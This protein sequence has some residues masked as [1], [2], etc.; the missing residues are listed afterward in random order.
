MVLMATEREMLYHTHE[1]TH[2]HTHTHTHYNFTVSVSR[3]L[4]YGLKFT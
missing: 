4:P 2:T 3:N 1:N